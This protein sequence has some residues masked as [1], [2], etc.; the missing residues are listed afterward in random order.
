MRKAS[1]VLLLALV[2]PLAACTKSAEEQIMENALGDGAKVDIK[3]DTMSVTSTD[4]TTVEFGGTQWPSDEETNHLPKLEKGTV[5]SVVTS[6]GYFAINIESI[7]KAD[8]EDY[9]GLIKADGFTTDAVTSQSADTLYYQA[10]DS[11]GR[12]VALSFDAVNSTLYIISSMEA[13]AAG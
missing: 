9:V 6:E 5:T 8:Y 3:G 7:T 11:T 2:L 10:S 13:E 4:G 12:F 1:A